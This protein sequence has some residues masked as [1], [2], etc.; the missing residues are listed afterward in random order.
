MLEIRSGQGSADVIAR[1]AEAASRRFHELD[2]LRAFAMLLGIVLHAALFFMPD[3]W[4]KAYSAEGYPAEMSGIYTLVFFAIHGFRMPVFF[5]LSGFFTALL[6]QRR[7]LRHLAIQ[8]LKRIG[9][10]LA[11]G[12]FTVIPI[13]TF[14]FLWTFDVEEFSFF[15]WPFIWLSTLS[16]LWFLWFL[17][18]LCAGFILAAKLGVKF[19]HP[20]IWWLAIPL[21]LVP[22]LLMHEPVFGPDTSDGLFLDPVVLAYY[23]PFF[24]FGAFLYQREIQISRWWTLALLPALT[25]VL[26][27]GLALLYDVK[28][29]WAK[30]LA[31]AFQVA[32]A[33]LMCFGLIGLFRLIAARERYWVRYLSDASYWLYLWHLALIVIAFELLVD[34]RVS[35]HIKFTVM[36]V[37]VTVILLVVY[38]FGVRYT[39]IGTMLNGRRT[40]R[41]SAGGVE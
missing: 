26:F 25:V 17:L 5:L 1:P 30:P 9:L 38:Q 14:A 24:V 2:A 28:E 4:S 37:A 8:R 21:A 40:R 23:V 20:V 33:W 41:R 22:Q 29:D 7:G 27:G 34:W 16:H 15:W 18:W 11:I 32:F 31:D 19:S 13:T 39:P 36:V 10:P 3:A 6:W 12:A 35:V